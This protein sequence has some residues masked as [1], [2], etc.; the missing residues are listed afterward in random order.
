[1]TFTTALVSIVVARARAAIRASALVC[2]GLAC[3]SSSGSTGPT[4]PQYNIVKP[5]D[6]SPALSGVPPDKQA[7]V[8]LVLENRG[9]STRRCYQEVLD[10][11]KDRAFNG[12]VVVM[13]SLDTQQRATNVKVM[14][15]TLPDSAVQTCLIST[16]KTF[17]YPK[18]DLP[19]DVQYTFQFRP[20][21]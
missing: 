16:L 19:G 10:E 18:L 8:E 2:V 1:M 5:S 9:V 11:K 7:E 14:G 21:Y 15:G 17:E 13:I 20:A 3:A 4:E 6:S 12:T